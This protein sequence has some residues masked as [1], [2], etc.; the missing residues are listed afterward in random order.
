VRR[1]GDTDTVA[2]VTNNDEHE[3]TNND[4]HGFTNNDGFLP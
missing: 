4:E 1:G 2:N 3:F